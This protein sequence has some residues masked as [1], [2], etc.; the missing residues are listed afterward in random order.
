MAT[1]NVSAIVLC[2]SFITFVS[3]GGSKSGHQSNSN[4]S[5]D[6]EQI[7]SLYRAVLK[8]L[9]PNSAGTTSGVVLLRINGDEFVVEETVANAPGGIKHYQAIMSGST[10]PTL[11]ENGDGYIDLKEGTKTF[12]NRLIPL[13]SNLDSQFAG[14]DFGPIANETNAYVYRRSTSLSL[15]LSDLRI[16]DPNGEDDLVKLQDKENINFSNRV[17]V[18]M[19]MNRSLP[20]TVEG[21]DTFTPSEGLPI[22]CGKLTAINSEND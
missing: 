3:C 2:L 19:G 1:R 15:M 16:E 6:A 18:V 4:K 11:D 21:D 8:P 20:A 13:D 7:G 5:Q 9:N 14:I 12:G 17:I 22:A 10:C